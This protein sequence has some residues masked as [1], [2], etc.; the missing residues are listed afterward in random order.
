MNNA[1]LIIQNIDQ[2]TKELLGLGQ[3]IESNLVISAANLIEAMNDKLNEY[4]ALRDSDILE[5]ELQAVSVVARSFERSYVNKGAVLTVAQVIS[6][7]ND[8]A[9]QMRAA[10]EHSSNELPP[11]GARVH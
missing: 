10:G 11:D 7:I 4:K 3:E 2:F 5:R 9:D 1:A 6:G 8:I